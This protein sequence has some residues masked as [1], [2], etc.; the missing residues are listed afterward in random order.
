MPTLTAADIA[1]AQQDDNWEGFGYLG[2]RR[3]ALDGSDPES[4]AQPELV[5]QVDAMLLAHVNALG[6]DYDRFFDFVNSRNGR[7]FGDE[8]F[9]GAGWHT[10]ETRFARTIGWN[11]LPSAS[12]R[13]R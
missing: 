4:P 2:T 7:Y 3:N 10:L 11:L 5:E 13:A 12:V 8:M 9:G 6:W 1:K